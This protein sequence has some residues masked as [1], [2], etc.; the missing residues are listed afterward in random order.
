MV[1]VVETYLCILDKRG[2]N[3]DIK[4]ECNVEKRGASHFKAV[5][6]NAK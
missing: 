6:R 3:F 5:M 4:S 2:A 1:L